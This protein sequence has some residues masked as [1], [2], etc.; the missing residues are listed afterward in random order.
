MGVALMQRLQKKQR[1]Q[2]KQRKPRQRRAASARQA[3]CAAWR[4]SQM[5]RERRLNSASR[6][7]PVLVVGHPP[8][9]LVLSALSCDA[10]PVDSSLPRIMFDTGGAARRD[11]LQPR[12]TTTKRFQPAQAHITEQQTAK[13][14]TQP[15]P[16]PRFMSSP[17]PTAGR[18]SGRCNGRRRCASLRRPPRAWGPSG[19]RPTCAPYCGRCSA[20]ARAPH[21]RPEG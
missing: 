20:S 8:C 10:P 5:T 14:Q 18:T 12:G 11:T 16:Q 7:Q 6:H 21:R 17:S 4:A 2:R 1:Q 13:T 15:R 19:W 3:S 9:A